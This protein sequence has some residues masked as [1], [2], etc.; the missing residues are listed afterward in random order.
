MPLEEAIGDR[1]D[2]VVV[3]FEAGRIEPVA[4]RWKT[5]EFD[6]ARVLSFRLDRSTRPNRMSIEVRVTTGEVMELTRR[7]GEAIWILSRLQT[8]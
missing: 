7:E 3:R 2:W 1:L 5:R 8:D 6:V 4:F